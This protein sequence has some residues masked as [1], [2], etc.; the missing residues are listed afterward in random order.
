MTNLLNHTYTLRGVFTNM[1]DNF[2]T[3]GLSEGQER[4]LDGKITRKELEKYQDSF[5]PVKAQNIEREKELKAKKNEKKELEA[6]IAKEEAKSEDE[7]NLSKIG[8]LNYELTLVKTRID[9]LKADLMAK[10]PHMKQILEK[11]TFNLLSSACPY[12]KDG[13]GI[14][15]E[16]NAHPG[17]SFDDLMNLTT[18]PTKGQNRP[19]FIDIYQKHDATFNDEVLDKIIKTKQ[20]RNSLDCD[21]T[22]PEIE[23][24]SYIKPN[25][26]K[27]CI[28]DYPENTFIPKQNE[29]A[30]DNFKDGLKMITDRIKNFYKL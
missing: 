22:P 4:K 9:Q 27:V 14:D 25:S 3:L 20:E 19:S 7:I 12:E 17:I 2:Q 15:K 16:G 28:E 23:N 13:T 29:E 1:S 6:K 26:P 10:P 8:K 24:S 18:K 30:K 21:P 11:D 5:D